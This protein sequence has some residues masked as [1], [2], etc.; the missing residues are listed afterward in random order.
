MISKIFLI[1]TSKFLKMMCYHCNSSN[2]IH[3]M[4][5]V[6]HK[7]ANGIMNSFCLVTSFLNCCLAWNPMDQNQTIEPG[8]EQM[9]WT[10][11]RQAPSPKGSSAQHTNLPC[12]SMTLLTSILSA[13]LKTTAA[14]KMLTR[15]ERKGGMV[16]GAPG[17]SWLY[18]RNLSYRQALLASPNHLVL[19]H[20]LKAGGG[21]K[22]ME[23][24]TGQQ[25][26][27]PNITNSYHIA[28]KEKT[29]FR[30]R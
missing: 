14:V 8:T 30:R 19:C 13:N 4:Y 22:H 16:G 3:T 24:E 1:I 17:L 2:I 26:L 12:E 6:T 20:L 18:K 21:S 10:E 29:G 25:V 5:E 23:P 7:S 28:I 11:E 9:E 15:R 27:G